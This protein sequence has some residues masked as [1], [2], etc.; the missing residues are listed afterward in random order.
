MVGAGSDLPIPRS[1]SGTR[2]VAAE[3]TW[4]EVETCADTTLV[5]A[6]TR[7]HGARG[8][9]MRWNGQSSRGRSPK[10]NCDA[11]VNTWD[12]NG[13]MIP[14]GQFRNRSTMVDFMV[15][16]KLTQFRKTGTT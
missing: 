16:K 5:V 10:D 3:R 12:N 11:G 14:T 15:L 9:E 1:I 2:R 6:G 13:W 8:A 4:R 7:R